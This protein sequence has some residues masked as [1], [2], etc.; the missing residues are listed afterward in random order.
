MI[1]AEQ[2]RFVP[3]ETED[4]ITIKGAGHH[5]WYGHHEAFMDAVCAN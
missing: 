3:E 4:A 5:V 2:S 1:R